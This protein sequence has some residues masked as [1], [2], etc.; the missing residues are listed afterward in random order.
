MIFFFFIF[1]VQKVQRIGND[2]VLIWKTSSPN[3][4]FE[5]LAS[6]YSVVKLPRRAQNILL[7]RKS[8][9]MCVIFGS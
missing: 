7:A 2:P 3:K 6:E 4:S 9:M 1:R 8:S 5:K